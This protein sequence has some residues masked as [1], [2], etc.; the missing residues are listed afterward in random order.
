M[1]LTMRP[2][3]LLSV[4][5]SPS[6]L[7][8]SSAWA[9]V[10]G[11]I[12][13]ASKSSTP[14]TALETVVQAAVVVAV[15]DA[16]IT[17]RPATKNSLAAPMRKCAMPLLPGLRLPLQPK[18]SVMLRRRTRLLY[19]M[20]RT[21]RTTLIRLRRCHCRTVL[22]AMTMVALLGTAAVPVVNLITILMEITLPMDTTVIMDGMDTADIT[23]DLLD[24]HPHHR[25]APPLFL[26]TSGA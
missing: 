25:S 12:V 4:T 15:T 14:G 3:S 20:R 7:E 2:T 18:A 8:V 22:A 26:L 17:R 24:P 21:G 23:V 11:A 13:G 6:G 5:A 10:A 16:A 19:A 1:A 9:D